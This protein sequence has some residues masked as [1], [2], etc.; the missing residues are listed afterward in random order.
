MMPTDIDDN[1]KWTTEWEV[2]THIPSEEEVNIGS[3]TEPNA[4]WPSWSV[5]LVCGNEDGLRKVYC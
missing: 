1:I 2:I 4:H 3:R 5:Y